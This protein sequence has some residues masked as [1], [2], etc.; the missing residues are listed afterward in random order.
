M[1]CKRQYLMYITIYEVVVSISSSF[2]FM[3]SSCTDNHDNLRFHEVPQIYLSFRQCSTAKCQTCSD[4]VLHEVLKSF[5][6]EVLWASKNDI[7]MKCQHS[8][9]HFVRR[10]YTTG[11]IS[12]LAL[13]LKHHSS[14]F[15]A[16]TKWQPL[17]P[18]FTHNTLSYCTA[19]DN[20]VRKWSKREFL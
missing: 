11:L 19:A 6:L 10:E 15:C 18:T 13:V 2:L 17:W 5:A 4:C 16:F 12:Q 9:S 1:K 8:C 14:G 20:I 3:L 7:F